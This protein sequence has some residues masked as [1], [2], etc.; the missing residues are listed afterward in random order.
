MSTAVPVTP[1][2]QATAE[3]KKV[4]AALK[5]PSHLNWLAVCGAALVA[6]IVGVILHI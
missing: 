5:Q 6:N 4:E 3:E 1:V 2:A